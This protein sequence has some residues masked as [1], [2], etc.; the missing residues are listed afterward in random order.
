MFV[1]RRLKYAVRVA[2]PNSGLANLLLEQF[3]SP[4]GELAAAGRYFTGAVAEDDPG[5]AG[6]LFD[7]VTEELSHQEII[8][9]VVAMLNQGREG[10]ITDDVE[11]KA[12]LYRSLTGAGSNSHITDLVYGGGAPLIISAGVPW[13]AAHIDTTGEPTADLRSNI[14][15]EAR[16]KIGYGGISWKSCVTAR[17]TRLPC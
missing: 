4:Q 9:S 17:S 7:I 3:K 13:T 1:D 2:A 8:E 6:T 16:A 14:A 10:K 11:Q 15:A 5:R 12:K